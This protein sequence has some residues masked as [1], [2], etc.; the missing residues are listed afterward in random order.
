MEAPQEEQD[1]VYVRLNEPNSLVNGLRAAN[2]VMKL[3]PSESKGTNSDTED[4]VYQKIIL[5]T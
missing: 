3:L 1:R 4:K 5:L 2:R